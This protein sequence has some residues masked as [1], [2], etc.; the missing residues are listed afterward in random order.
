MAAQTQCDQ[1]HVLSR[2][3]PANSSSQWLEEL[4]E[5]S[6]TSSLPAPRQ[7]IESISDP[8]PPSGQFG[9]PELI[10]S[11]YSFYASSSSS[12]LP[13]SFDQLSPL[14]SS[15]PATLDYSQSIMLGTSADHNPSLLLQPY[16]DRITHLERRVCSGFSCCEIPLVDLHALISHYEDEHCPRRSPHTTRRRASSSG[17]HQRPHSPP[18]IN[19][20]VLPFPSLYSATPDSTASTPAS[21]RSSSVVS[22]PPTPHTPLSPPNSVDSVAIV[23]HDQPPLIDYNPYLG[24]AMNAPQV[25]AATTQYP[26]SASIDVISAFGPEYDFSRDYASYESAFAEQQ[27]K[28]LEVALEWEQQQVLMHE[29]LY[30]APS[31][32][33]DVAQAVELP[34][35]DEMDSAVAASEEPAPSA[36]PPDVKRKSSP[37]SRR[38]TSVVAEVAPSNDGGKVSKQRTKIAGPLFGTST[39]STSRK[40][41]KAFKCPHPGCIKAYLNP[42]GL[43]YHLEKG[44]CNIVPP[45]PSPDSP[46]TD[47]LPLASSSSPTT[48]QPLASSTDLTAVQ[49]DYEFYPHSTTSD[50]FISTPAATPSC[51]PSGHQT[52]GPTELPSPV[53]GANLPTCDQSVGTGNSGDGSVP[54]IPSERLTSTSPTSKPSLTDGTSDGA[55]PSRALDATTPLSHLPLSRSF[56]SSSASSL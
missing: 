25:Q 41:E 54:S 32:V 8:C 27:R 28:E 30:A 55:V 6:H 10:G 18:K 1:P 9:Q 21:S 44:T 11:P 24:L 7:S 23:S 48:Q 40:R 19:T 14:K 53:G 13:S 26:Y 39:A 46:C 49:P 20:A 34:V 3:C 52:H 51:S 12:F 16:D 56:T 37:K 43:K 31:P 42:N 15:H 35:L 4:G 29:L 50:S 5:I 17:S 2:N 45:A 47:S 33:E 38:A 22:S 36:V